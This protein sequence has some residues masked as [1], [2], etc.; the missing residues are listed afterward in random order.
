[1]TLTTWIDVFLSP[2]VRIRIYPEGGCS[3]SQH[4]P[5]IGWVLADDDIDIA[6]EVLDALLTA[7]SAMFATA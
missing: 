2:T 4:V 3:I 7:G 1:M 6:D 5:S